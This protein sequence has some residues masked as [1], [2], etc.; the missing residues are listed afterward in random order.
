MYKRK[1]LSGTSYDDTEVRKEIIKFSREYLG[2]SMKQNPKQ[3]KIDLIGRKKNPDVGVEVE[4]GGW[5]GDFWETPTYC[6]LTDLGVSTVNIPIRKEKYWKERFMWYGKMKVNPSWKKNI[7]VRTND[8]F[9]Q[10]M[11]IRPEVITDPTKLIY[12]TFQANNC[13]ELEDWMS[14]KRED[15]ETYNLINEEYILEKWPI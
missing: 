15:V 14:F 6:D 8:D 11:V 5:K 7:F 2:L 10:I 1:K 4:K 12:T 13:D 3:R 9:T